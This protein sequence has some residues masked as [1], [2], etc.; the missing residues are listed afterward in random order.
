MK[1]QT[2]EAIQHAK[3]ANVPIVV[4]VNKIDKS[5]ADPERVK[6]ELSQHDV[7]PEAWGGD[8]IFVP[9]SAKTGQ[10]IDEL[11]ESLLIPSRIIRIKSGR[12]YACTWC[13]D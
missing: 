1:P 9:I 12:R 2:V 13:G 3:A 7:I 4:A 8:T 5:G 6:H 10:G 11:L